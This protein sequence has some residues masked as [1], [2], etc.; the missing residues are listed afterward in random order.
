MPLDV[1]EGLR[2]V[3]LGLDPSE[4]PEYR[5]DART[6]RE[7]Q[8][9]VIEFGSYCEKRVA[10]TNAP[11]GIGKQV[12]A[13]SIAKITNMRTVIGTA[14]KAL[15]DQYVRKLGHAGLV[16]IKGR[17]NYQCAGFG[18]VDCRG[19]VTLG[20]KY[21]KGPSCPYRG[22]LERARGSGLV[23]ANYAYWLTANDKG[24]GLARVGEDREDFG[25]NPVELLVLD[26][27][28]QAPRW[29]EEYLAVRVYEG[30]VKRW[31]DPKRLG[32]E[33]T[34]WVGLAGGVLDGLGEDLKA[35]TVVLKG[36]GRS[37]TKTELDEH[38]R[39]E[40]LK[41]KLER[42]KGMSGGDWVIERRDGTRW[43][44]EWRF[45]VVWPGRYAEQYL[46]CKVGKVVM[47]S[48]TLR[49]KTLGLLGVSRGE[50]EF[51]EWPRVFPANRHPI[52]LCPARGDDGKEVRVD[53]RTTE[54]DMGLW[55]EHLDRIL[56]GRL[57]RRGIIQTVS[58]DRAKYILD[59]SRHRD[60]M[61]GN[62]SDPDS[63]TAVEIAEEFRRREPPAILVSPSFAIGW[64]FPGVECEYIIVCKV[65][66][67]P[68]MGKVG[69]AREQRDAQYSAYLTMQ[70]LVQ[71]CGRGMRS[72][73]DR[74]EV[75]VTDGHLGWFLGKFGSLG[76]DWFKLA[77]R[78][79]SEIPVAPEKLQK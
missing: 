50:Y 10:A 12:I 46:F 18:H 8:L 55:L 29:L 51:R 56:D 36:K 52:Y 69:R 34:E 7:V 62:T 21:S 27:A 76:P 31:C 4:F 38:H 30:E 57:D 65:P 61:L 63:E 13:V 24:G 53:R 35:R 28:D 68:S 74:C 32:E 79:V 2:P 20:C 64:D 60:S 3:D 67:K 54:A 77:V 75:F 33:V 14:T 19:G 37:A 72:E 71:G 40:K 41:S 42:I 9:E 17:A 39:L 22:A 1:L 47:M 73:D 70:E 25:D 15:Q 44:R 6:G 11:T 5:R 16:E 59:S 48:A 45:D 26:E 49:P 58:Y 66:F 23:V 43:G 78:R